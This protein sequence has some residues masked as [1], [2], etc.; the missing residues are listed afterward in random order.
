VELDEHVGVDALLAGRRSGES[1]PSLERWLAVRNQ[2]AT[3]QTI[4]LVEYRRRRG[5]DT[6]HWCPSCSSFPDNDCESVRGSPASGELCNECQSRAKS[7]RC[8]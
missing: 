4:S 8:G 5:Q 7:N 6:W 1:L 2:A 3:S